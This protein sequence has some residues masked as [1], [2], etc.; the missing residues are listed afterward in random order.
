MNSLF[1]RLKYLVL[2]QSGEKYRKGA[3]ETRKRTLFKF[4]LKVLAAVAVT[5]V[6]F[7]VLSYVKASFFFVFDKELFT[8]VIFLTQI[9]GIV[10][11]VG[12]MMNVLYNAKENLILMAFPCRYNEIFI[13]KIIVYALEELRKSCFFIL[14]FLLSYAFAAG[15]GWVYWAQLIPLWIFLV[16]FPV[17]FGAI[18]SIPAIF[19]K[20]YLENHPILFGVLISMLLGGVFALVTYALS[21][22]PTPIRLIA[23]Y[24]SFMKAFRVILIKINRFSLFYRFIGNAMFGEAV[25]L[26]LPIVCVIFVAA[27]LLCFFVAMP[28]YFRAASTSTEHSTAGRHRVGRTHCHHLFMTF[29]RK[30]VKLMFRSSESL[31]SALSIILIFPM[32]S[33]VMNV[34]VAAVRTNLY[35]DY[36]TIAFNVMIT[37]SLLS[38]YNANCASAISREGSEFAILKAAPSDTTLATWAKLALTMIVDILAV[39]T[40]CIVITF[41]TTLSRRDIALM[42]GIILPVSLGNVLWSFRIDLLNPKVNDYAVKGDAVSDNPNITKAL[43]VG[44]LISTLTGVINLLLLI[45]KY[46][47]GWARMYL[48]AYGFFFVRLY[49]YKSNLKVYF[50]DIQG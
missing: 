15:A 8:T 45:D 12:S 29:F 23:F 49:L 20:R 13:S 36:M 32:I 5:G 48:I 11:C 34:I 17:L 3:K 42:A 7:A 41:T 47:S 21:F 37:L 4:F 16:L 46:S 38:T 19:V 35:G 50:N 18:I 25:R 2:L 31:N 30:E 33:Y 1:R 28:F 10:T 24:H 43:I 9:I 39:A 22:L 6:L 26:Y 27:L 40:M 14:P 44:F